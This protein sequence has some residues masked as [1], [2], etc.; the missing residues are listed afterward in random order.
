M[1]PKLLIATFLVATLAT[2][3]IATSI[4]AGECRPL[5]R[6]AAA[7]HDRKIHPVRRAGKAVFVA[8]RWLL[9]R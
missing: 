5:Q 3:L 4:E 8:G 2:C 7:V 6:V 9:G 1:L